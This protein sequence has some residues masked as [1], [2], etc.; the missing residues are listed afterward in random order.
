MN[1]ITQIDLRSDLAGKLQCAVDQVESMSYFRRRCFFRRQYK[2]DWRHL[3]KYRAVLADDVKS[4]D[5]I[6]DILIRSQLWLS[7]SADFNDPFDTSATIFFEGTL[8]DK[9]KRFDTLIKRQEPNMNWKRRQAFVTKIMGDHGRT[10]GETLQEIQNDLTKEF[11]VCSFA[12]DAKSILL[13]F[14]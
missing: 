3:F 8:A 2:S 13:S 4:I 10:F 6:K 7:S 14:P 12:G 9:R 11:G 1:K 5:R